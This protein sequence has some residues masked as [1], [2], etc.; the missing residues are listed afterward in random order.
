[1]TQDHKPV[2]L[3][4]KPSKKLLRW[5]L[6]IH[7]LA[8]LALLALGHS[9]AIAFIL[10][11]T[12]A[13]SFFFTYRRWKNPLWK[14]IICD[15]GLW[16]LMTSEFV[17]AVG[18]GLCENVS[19]DELKEKIELRQFYHFGELCI[20]RLKFLD[21][22][23]YKGLTT[24]SLLPDSCDADSLRQLRQLLIL[25]KLNSPNRKF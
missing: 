11:L 16:S 2:E 8:S 25:R 21:N 9:L 24:I 6:V 5:I 7:V 13:G 10:Q 23:R 22:S 20:L 18:G 3:N 17:E 15:K 1:M 4:L 14:K 12:I 19:N